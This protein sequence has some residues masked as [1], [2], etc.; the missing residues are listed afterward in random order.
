MIK[1]ELS[2]ISWDWI[3]TWKQASINTF[4]CLLGCSIGD[5]ETIGFF[6]FFDIKLPVIYIMIL[7]IINGL[8]TYILLET[9]IL[10][11]KMTFQYAIKT[12]LWMSIIS[13]I[14]MEIVMNLVDYLY[15][16]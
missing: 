9:V 2:E 16:G 10:L 13:M 7:A 15:T 5:F 8:I 11:R 6:Q 14:S 4:W 12:A 3:Y 1:L